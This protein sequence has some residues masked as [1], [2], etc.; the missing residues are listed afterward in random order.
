SVRTG[1]PAR[2]EKHLHGLEEVRHAVEQFIDRELVALLNASGAWAGLDP[3]P[4]PVWIGVQSIR[5][6]LAV[7][8]FGD[9]PLE[10]RFEHIDGVIVSE[11]VHPVWFAELTDEQR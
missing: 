7:P 10:I 6:G 3:R 2:M 8:K 11:V 1:Q 4:G 9:E 5:A